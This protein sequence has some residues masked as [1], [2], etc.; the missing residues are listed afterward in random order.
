MKIT[1]MQFSIIEKA[2]LYSR[3]GAT[4]TDKGLDKKEVVEVL[5]T[6]T[7][8]NVL[9]LAL[10]FDQRERGGRRSGAGWP[11]GKKRKVKK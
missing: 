8:P 1:N 7:P 5:E 4:L 3:A 6:L 11:K 9:R 2:I 10:G